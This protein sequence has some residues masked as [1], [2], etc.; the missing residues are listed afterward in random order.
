M[1]HNSFQGY[2]ASLEVTYSSWFVQDFPS[3]SNEIPTHSRNLSYPSISHT[4]DFSRLIVHS[5]ILSVVKFDFIS[6]TLV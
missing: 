4:F 1:V 2:G 3:F 5:L 6:L